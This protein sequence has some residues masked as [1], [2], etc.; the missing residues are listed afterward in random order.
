[1]TDIVRNA[2]ALNRFEI[3]DGGEIAGFAE[4]LD[5]DGQRIFHHTEIGE[6]FGGKGLAS[7]L[8]QTALTETSN[9]GLRTVPVCPF[10][11]KFIGKH[12]EFAAGA[13]EVTPAVLELLENS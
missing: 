10:V 2:P 13:D 1:M 5:H 9:A 8:I 3:Y 7:K 4:Y 12:D 6:R 11:A